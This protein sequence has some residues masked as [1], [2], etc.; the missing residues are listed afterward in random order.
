MGRKNDTDGDILL[1]VGLIMLSI[2]AMPLVGLYLILKPNGNTLLGAILIV[3]G[4][5]LWCM[6]FSS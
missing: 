4:I 2:I 5:I 6:Y 3:I 1:F